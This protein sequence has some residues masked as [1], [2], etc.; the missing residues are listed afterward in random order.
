VTYIVHAGVYPHPPIIIPEVGGKEVKKVKN[1][2][3]AM[4]KMA[5]RVRDV[6]P[7]TLV[8]IS[9]HGTVLKDAVAVLGMKHLSGSLARFGVP[10]INLSYPSDNEL[11]SRIENEAESVGIATVVLSEQNTDLPEMDNTLDHGALVPLYFLD[12]AGV[13]LPLVHIT[14]GFLP[15][16]ELYSFGKAVARAIAALGRRVAV[17]A[18]GDLSHRL[19]PGA[20]AGYSPEGKKFDEQIVQLLRSFDVAAILDMDELFLDRAGECGYRSLLICLG[21]LEGEQV[22]PEIL[23]YEGPF[24]VGYLVADLTPGKGDENKDKGAP[25]DRTRESEHVRLARKALETFVQTGRIMPPPPESVLKKTKAGSFVSLKINGQLRGCIGTIEPVQSSLAEEIIHNAISAGTKDPRFRTL[26]PDELELLDY[27][28][29]VLSQ[30]E[31]VSD[32]QDLDPHKYGVIVESNGRRG[33]LLPD[34]E[35]VDTVDE[36]LAIALQKAGISPRQK[37]RI[38]RFLVDR[39]H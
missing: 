33:L 5:G 2:A 16:N 18:S 3:M 22:R 30:A 38:F 29:D 35:G 34:L 8:V 1:T 21:I 9:P 36:Q 4:E 24:G 15:P 12:K 25:G 13:R 37:F 6:S 26:T 7:D 27:S 10:G 23:S 32:S 31:E 39:F 28:V 19:I 20:P 17:I 11:V 14:F